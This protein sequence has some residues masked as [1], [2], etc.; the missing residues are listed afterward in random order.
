MS[1]KAV[2]HWG[3]AEDVCIVVEEDDARNTFVNHEYDIV[4]PKYVN[5]IQIP[6][7]KLQAR[8]LAEQ[9]FAMAAKC[10]DYEDGLNEYMEK[11]NV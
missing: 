7:T 6:M 5:Q 1:I 4:N 8:V 10:D 9:L 3:M 11:E 2:C